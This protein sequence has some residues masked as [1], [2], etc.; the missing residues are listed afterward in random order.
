MGYA[1]TQSD[2]DPLLQ[3]GEF[4]FLCEFTLSEFV[5]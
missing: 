4:P 2:V 3:A 1:Q 5:R